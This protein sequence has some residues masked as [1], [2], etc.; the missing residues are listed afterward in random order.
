MRKKAVN[1]KAS[2]SFNHECDP[3]IKGC[4]LFYGSVNLG[5][6]LGACQ[7]SVGASDAGDLCP[8]EFHV[9]TI[10]LTMQPCYA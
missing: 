4:I 9:L 6:L 8:Q 10:S 7:L 3:S 5:A 1:R 2:M